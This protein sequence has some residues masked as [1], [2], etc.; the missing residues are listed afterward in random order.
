MMMNQLP[1]IKVFIGTISF[2]SKNES[3]FGKLS[4]KGT[5]SKM[6]SCNPK[7]QFQSNPE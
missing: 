5:T 7:L 2:D 6:L 1:D 4:N 3:L